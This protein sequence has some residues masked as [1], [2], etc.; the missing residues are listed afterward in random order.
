MNAAMIQELAKGNV[1]AIGD[2]IITPIDCTH[3]SVK[4]DKGY[5]AIE[6]NAGNSVTLK[7]TK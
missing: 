2:F 5:I 6:P 4:T 3:I 1:Y 7:S